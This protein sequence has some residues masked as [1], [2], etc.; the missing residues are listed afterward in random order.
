MVIVGVKYVC[1]NGKEVVFS[2][3]CA[4]IASCG[5]WARFDETDIGAPVIVE[6]KTK[7]TMMPVLN[8]NVIIASTLYKHANGLAMS[9][10][11]D[12]LLM[13]IDVSIDASGQWNVSAIQPTTEPC[14]KIA[15][16]NDIV[17]T[18]Q[19]RLQV[20]FCVCWL[21]AQGE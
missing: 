7:L 21:A 19:T 15:S 10:D 1:Y 3:R 2:G 14:T 12:T 16:F 17:I 4:E 5:Q 6:K 20:G 9:C 8:D 18:N 13:D 11:G